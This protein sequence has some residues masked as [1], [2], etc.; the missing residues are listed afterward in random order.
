MGRLQDHPFEPIAPFL[1]RWQARQDKDDGLHR[2]GC[3]PSCTLALA[4]SGCLRL[5][6]YD[7]V[8][9]GHVC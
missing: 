9:A 4:A 7:N 6:R 2:G 5:H 8:N 3:A 1:A